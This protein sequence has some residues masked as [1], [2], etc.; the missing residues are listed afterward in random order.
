VSKTH[1][2]PAMS[3]EKEA[4]IAEIR[5]RARKVRPGPAQSSGSTEVSSGNWSRTRDPSS[6]AP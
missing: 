3:F 5:G 4:A 2:K 6:S 1:Q